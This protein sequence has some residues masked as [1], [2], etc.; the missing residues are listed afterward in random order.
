[1][2]GA[3]DCQWGNKTSVR[4]TW[5]VPIA[6]QYASSVKSMPTPFLAAEMTA[7]INP[8]ALRHHDLNGCRGTADRL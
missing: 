6:L 4:Q 3:A 7:L 8:F 5:V 1:V 2:S